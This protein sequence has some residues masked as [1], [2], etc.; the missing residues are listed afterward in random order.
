MNRTLTI[1]Q[2]QALS[3]QARQYIIEMIH[4]AGSGHPGGSLSCVDFITT[5]YFYEMNIFPHDPHNPNRDRFV[6]SKGHSAPA[7]YAVLAMCGFF[8]VDELK[9]LRKE[10]SFLQGHPN[11]QCPGID[12][13]TGSLGLGFGCAVGMAASALID[14][15][16][17]RVF[18]VLGDGELQEGIV[19]EACNI[20]HKYNLTNLIAFVDNNH[21]Q[22]DGF[23]DDIMPNGNLIDKFRSFGFQT[24][25]INGND[26]QQIINCFEI[27][28]LTHCKRPAVIIGDTI[29]GK[30]VPFMENQP[31][32]HGIAPNDSQTSIAL[33]VLRGV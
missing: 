19:W 6:L 15:K 22:L 14:H 2:L 13:P 16:D 8:S 28:R 20:A 3:T 9:S 17:F 21:L 1:P 10:G 11:L 33:S 32:W 25:H 4:E 7:L 26:I 12:I 23:T 27:I 30:G 18:S 29:K 31:S 5:A 24:Y